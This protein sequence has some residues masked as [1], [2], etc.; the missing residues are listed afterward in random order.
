MVLIYV[1][2]PID[3][4]A[5]E[6]AELLLKERFTNHV[7]IIH[8][9]ECMKFDDGAVNKSTETILLIKAKALL[10]N[11]I[12]KRILELNYSPAPTIFSVPMT[13][14]DGAYH[15]FLLRDVLKV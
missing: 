13:Q 6:I 1:S 9:N 10:Y 12:Q 3:A 11:Q 7:N 5:A 8:S 15:D 4:Q 2:L 14:I